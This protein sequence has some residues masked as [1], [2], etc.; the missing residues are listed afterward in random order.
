MLPLSAF[1][2]P[3]NHGNFSGT[4]VD[5]LDVTEDTNSGDTQ[6]LFGAPNISGDSLDFDPVGFSANSSGGGAPDQTDGQL[7]FM[8]RAKA[9]K[10]IQSISLTEAGDTSLARSIVSN[11]DAFTQVTAN[12]FIDV[13]EVNFLPVSTT[14]NANGVM[15]FT[16][17]GGDYLLSTDGAGN[18]TYNTS[19]TGNFF[20]ELGPLLAANGI[21]GLVTK[22]GINL[23]N[24]LTASS[25]PNS[26]A[27]IAKKDFDGVVITVNPGPDNV[28]PEPS[29]CVLAAFGLLAAF[30]ARRLRG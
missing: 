16:P 18:P 17:S 22:V 13:L 1:A 15:T 23:D 10:A 21:T 24:T 20:Y 6:P 12:I 19:W 26:S 2:A 14:L 4:T 9:G 29:A 27:L 25:G 3:I 7:K 8:I 30:G 5:Y 28:V 11:E